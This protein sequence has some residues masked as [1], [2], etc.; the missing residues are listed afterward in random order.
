MS[1]TELW[2]FIT[3]AHACNVAVF[4]FLNSKG[5]KPFCR[6]LLLKGSGLWPVI[7]YQCFMQ[8][9]LCILGRHIQAYCGNTLFPAACKS[10]AC[11]G[12]TYTVGLASGAA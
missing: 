12:A 7:P 9:L 4:A 11:A 8:V 2:H 5:E 6:A 10:L 3:A 1:R